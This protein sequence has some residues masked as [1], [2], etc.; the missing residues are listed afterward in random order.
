MW[1]SNG[2]LHQFFMEKLCGLPYTPQIQMQIDQQLISPC[3]NV[4]ALSTQ[5]LSTTDAKYFFETH[6]GD[7]RALQEE[8]HAKFPEHWFCILKEGFVL[9]P[10][11][12]YT[13]Y[14]RVLDTRKMYMM[15]THQGVTDHFQ[16]YYDKTKYSY[17]E[18]LL[19]EILST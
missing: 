5:T 8:L 1:H 6:V 13:I 7:V 18:F 10:K 15:M 4:I 9:P 17:E 2:Y 19:I 16:L 3:K 14:G 11:F 12:D